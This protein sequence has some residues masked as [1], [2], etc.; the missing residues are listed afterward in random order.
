V[1]NVPPGRPQSHGNADADRHD[2]D[3]S[4]CESN[5]K[6]THPIELIPLPRPLMSP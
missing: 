6:V 1:K 5:E 4:E 2:E 3:Q